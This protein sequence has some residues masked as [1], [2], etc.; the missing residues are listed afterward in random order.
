MKYKNFMLKIL[1]LAIICTICSILSSCKESPRICYYNSM[2]NYDN[3][4][5]TVIIN[6]GYM[7]DQGHSFDKEETENGFDITFHFIKNE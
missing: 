1:L 2:N 5:I 3:N 6:E 7:L 4:N